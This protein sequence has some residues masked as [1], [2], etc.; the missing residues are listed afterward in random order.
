MPR[1]RS[2][3]GEPTR[4]RLEGPALSAFERQLELA[5]AF[6]NRGLFSEHFLLER[7]PEWPEFA[8]PDNGVLY[9]RLQSLWRDEQ[10]GLVGANEAQTEE[11][12]VRPVLAALGFAYTVQAPLRVGP[13]WR[14]PDYGLFLSEADRR[15]ALPLEGAERFARAACVA[16]AKRFD[17]P[18]DRRRAEGALSEDPVAQIITYVSATRCPW[19]ILTNGRHWRL[20]AAERDLLGV[21]VVVALLLPER[22]SEDEDSDQVRT[23]GSDYPL[24]PLDLVVPPMPH[25]RAAVADAERQPAAVTAGPKEETDGTV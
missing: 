7:L 14:Q 6:A 1:S 11:R 15:A 10:E 9:G 22:R 13:G 12:W 19:G 4:R 24:P 8:R 23:A 5:G 21:L 2:S 25:R 17:R 3:P 18:L 16:D 20:Y